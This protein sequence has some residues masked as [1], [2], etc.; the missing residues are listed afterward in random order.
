MRDLVP[1]HLHPAFRALSEDLS[2]RVATARLPIQPY[3]G[4]RDPAR[5]AELFAF[6][7]ASGVGTP[8]RHKTF[9]AAWQSSHQHGFAE[10]WVWWSDGAWTWDAPA[11]YSWAQF[12]EL[13]DA[14]GLE[15][16][17]FEEPHV[18]MP[19]FNA[20]KILAGAAYPPNGDESWEDNMEAAAMAWGQLERKDRNGLVQPGAPAV[21]F[22]GL[23]PER[24]VPA[25]MVYDDERG[26]CL[27]E[28][29]ASAPNVAGSA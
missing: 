12:F 16:L 10:D 6:G 15:R 22:G 28:D 24:P 17:H 19:G 5:Q 14:V 13:V 9:E 26:L 27:P 20:R 7:R 29:V 21:L 1:G 8:G 23:R 2:H 18:Q 4:W 11:G 3:E 25:G